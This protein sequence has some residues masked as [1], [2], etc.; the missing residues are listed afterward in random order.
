M[1]RLQLAGVP[2]IGLN[3]VDVRQFGYNL[4]LAV[5]TGEARDRSTTN[6][7][8]ANTVGNDGFLAGGLLAVLA[9]D[10]SSVHILVPS[11]EPACMCFCKCHDF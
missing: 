3:S 5:F 1:Q 8:I 11:G 6:L 4:T 9:T 2:V 10:I 7:S